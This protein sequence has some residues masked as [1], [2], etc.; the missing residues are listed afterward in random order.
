[1]HALVIENHAFVAILIEEELRQLGFATVE[2]VE[3]EEEAIRSAAEQCPDII[4]ADQQLT[5]GT[6]V[7]AIRVICEKR[8]IPVVFI[9]GYG[10]QVAEA[11]PHAVVLVK[12]FAPR[13]LREAVGQAIV[14]AQ[15]N[16]GRSRLTHIF[17]HSGY[18]RF[19]PIADISCIR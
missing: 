7:G 1:M 12:P 6:G 14:S 9:T 3:S 19:R 13:L 10:E 18:G 4:T 5:T 8:P 16:A 11:I 2:I 17:T 15:R